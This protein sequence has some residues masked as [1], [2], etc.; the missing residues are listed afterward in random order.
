M[1]FNLPWAAMPGKVTLIPTVTKFLELPSAHPPARCRPL[2]LAVTRVGPTPVGAEVLRPTP[3]VSRRSS[4]VR[5]QP[6]TPAAR[7][8]PG[9]LEAMEASELQEAPQSGV[10]LIVAEL[11]APPRAAML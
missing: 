11:V 10:S 2:P 6:Y 5:A 1:A 3:V 7:R 8:K 4:G 9:A